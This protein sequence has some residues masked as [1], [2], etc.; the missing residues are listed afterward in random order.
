MPAGWRES[1][2]RGQLLLSLGVE[3]L[4]DLRTAST[5]VVVVVLLLSWE[6]MPEPIVLLASGLAGLLLHSSA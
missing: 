1:T 6:K 5:S 4:Y 2:S 3:P